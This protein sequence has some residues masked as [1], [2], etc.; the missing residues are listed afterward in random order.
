MRDGPPK[1]PKR[2]NTFKPGQS[3]NPA[4]RPPGAKNVITQEHREF[5]REI[6]RDPEYR[7]NLRA[8]VVAGIAGRMEEVVTQY[9]EGKVADKVDVTIAETRLEEWSKREPEKFAT[10]GEQV[11][12]AVALLA[13]VEKP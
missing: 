7:K 2:K 8:R 12:A 5:C 10:L 9:A 11:R 13:E 1:I 3:G 6:I 4:G